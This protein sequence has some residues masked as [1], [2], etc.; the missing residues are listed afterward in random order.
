MDGT[1]RTYILR[2]PSNY[3]NQTAYR[4]IFAYHWLNGNANQVALGGNGGSTD[5]PFYGLWDQANNTTIFVAPEGIDAGWANTNNRDLKFTDAMLQ[6]IQNDMC[7]D[8][9]RI[10]LLI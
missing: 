3:T 7:I 4:L 10:L 5:D 8:N 6:Q 1:N 2:T 9:S